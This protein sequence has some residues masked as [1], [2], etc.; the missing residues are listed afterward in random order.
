M[1]VVR[2]GGYAHM[3]TRTQTQVNLEYTFTFMQ[4]SIF[5]PTA[6]NKAIFTSNPGH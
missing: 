1:R 4:Q 2:K 3:R 6:V 5:V